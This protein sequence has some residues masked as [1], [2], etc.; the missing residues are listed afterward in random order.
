MK[1][2]NLPQPDIHL[3]ILPAYG[4]QSREKNGSAAGAP[5]LIIEVTG[6]TLS[7]D[8]G[9]SSKSTALPVSANT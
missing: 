4:G 1:G 5:E 6:S 9:A 8:L 7:R 2:P 3:R